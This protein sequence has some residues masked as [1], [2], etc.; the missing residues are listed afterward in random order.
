MDRSKLVKLLQMS[1]NKICYI[2]GRPFVTASPPLKGH[3]TPSF[4][5]M[6]VVAKRV[7][8]LRCHLVLGMEVGLCR[9]NVVL[10]GSQLPLKGTQPPV[11]GQCLL[12]PN[13]LMDEDVTWCGSRPRSRPHC[14]RQ[15]PSPPPAK[16]AQQ[17]PPSFRPMSIVA[18][19]AISATAE[20]FSPI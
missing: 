6:S 4:R 14:V 8:G 13:V 15:E 9:G 5:P 2:F 1:C 19:A 18:T 17:P 7:D 20:L 10:H 12:W 16:G 11:F 3:S